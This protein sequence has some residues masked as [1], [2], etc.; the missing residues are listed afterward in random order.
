[1]ADPV[2]VLAL[3]GDYAMHERALARLGASARRVRR[4]AEL[5][6]CRALVMP[7]GESTTISRLIDHNGLRAP[8]RDFARAHP[9]LGTCAGLILLAREL[10]PEVG[11]HHHG[12]EPLGL[13]DVKVRRNGY[14]RQVDSFQAALELAGDD[15]PLPG[16]FIRAPR[17]V[18]VGAGCEVIVR[19]GEEPAA[20]RQGNILGATFH[21]ELTDDTRLLSLLLA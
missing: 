15:A 6:G 1:M 20:V 21:P 19:H 2:G 4:P 5:D 11:D 7:G 10:E 9:V 17:I 13:L 16:V 3:Q 12:V 18:E 8:L 14:G